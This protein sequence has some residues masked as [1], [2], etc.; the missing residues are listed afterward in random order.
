MLGLT[1][2]HRSDAMKA[3]TLSFGES[4][5]YDEGPI[6]R[7]MAQK[8]GAEYHQISITQKDLADSFP[9]A[10]VQ[11]EGPAPNAHGWQSIC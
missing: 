9:D 6:A 10:I 4:A 7:E 11:A 1:A 5:L 8:A 3:F 2:R